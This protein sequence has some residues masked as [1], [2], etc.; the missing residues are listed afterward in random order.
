MSDNIFEIGTDNID[1]TKI[2]DEIRMSVEKKTRDGLFVDSR[3]SRAE[4]LNL[5]NL[6]DDESFMTFYLE[7]LKDAII[8]DIS[9]FEITERRSGMGFF[10]VPVKRLIW[11]FL[12]FYTY[13][14]WSQQNQSNG[15]LLSAI[16]SMNTQY[17]KK[18]S[19]LEERLATIEKQNK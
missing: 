9:D 19:Q 1:V 8:V 16:E 13:R 7:C 10:L 14:L 5:P 18:I 17:K 11:K 2:V 6:K 12:K 3:I 15:L 4:K